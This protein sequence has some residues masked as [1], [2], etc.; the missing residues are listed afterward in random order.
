[1]ARSLPAAPLAAAEPLGA[2]PPWWPTPP[3]LLALPPLPPLVAAAP[4]PPP[5]EEFD[6]PLDDAPRSP[7]LMVCRLF[8]SSLFRSLLQEKGHRQ[9]ELAQRV[10]CFRAPPDSLVLLRRGLCAFGTTPRRRVRTRSFLTLGEFIICVA[11]SSLTQCLLNC[12][13]FMSVERKRSVHRHNK[14]QS[15]RRCYRRRAAAGPGS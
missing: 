14:S 3:A 10:S 6:A 11:R 9:R 8:R 5:D 1:M 4:P 15:Q 12:P 13:F 2:P 7:P